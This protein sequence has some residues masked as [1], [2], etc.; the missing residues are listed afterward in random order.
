M[1]RRGFTL[2]ELLIVIGIIAIL[3]GFILATYGPAKQRARDTQRISDI[4]Q[5]QVALE[6]YF[7]DPING[8]QYP[9]TLVQVPAS[10]NG[11]GL[12]C[13]PVTGSDSNTA[14]GLRCLTSTSQTNSEPYLPSIPTDPQTGLNYDYYSNSNANADTGVQYQSY[15]IGANLEVPNSQ[16]NALT[17]AQSSC[18]GVTWCPFT[19]TTYGY[20]NTGPGTIHDNYVVCRQ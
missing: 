20:S 15:C 6:S 12:P 14:P 2:I 1:H 3:A 4:S 9:P 7:E 13:H 11:Q 18:A 10:S 17:A 8:N 19:S 16:S 5:I